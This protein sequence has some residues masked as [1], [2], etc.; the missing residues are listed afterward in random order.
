MDNI[1]EIFEEAVQAIIVVLFMVTLFGN[2]LAEV[3]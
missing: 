2:I 3:V 1:I